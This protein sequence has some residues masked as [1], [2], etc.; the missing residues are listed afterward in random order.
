LLFIIDYL[1]KKEDYFANGGVPE[2]T[3]E[4]SRRFYG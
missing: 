4:Y 2:S 1:E 3:I